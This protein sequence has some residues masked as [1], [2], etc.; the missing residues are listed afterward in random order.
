M[1]T[2]EPEDFASIAD[3]AVSALLRTYKEEAENNPDIL[4]TDFI[5]ASIA[6]SQTGTL[7]VWFFEYDPDEDNQELKHADR[8]RS[9]W[10]GETQVLVH[11]N[12]LATAMANHLLE[13]SGTP[14][15]EGV[16]DFELTI[17]AFYELAITTADALHEAKRGSG[18]D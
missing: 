13:T 4:P 10:F 17:N 15:R 18:N 16:I 11:T 5:L 1:T 9:S 8:H 12:E 2:N 7:A 6:I 14:K 3:G